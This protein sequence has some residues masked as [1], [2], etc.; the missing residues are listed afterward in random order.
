M[1]Q[2]EHDGPMSQIPAA[3]FGESWHLHVDV[4]I[5]TVARAELHEHIL[6]PP[7]QPWCDLCPGTRTEELDEPA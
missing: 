4:Q 5:H 6:F 1:R 2:T 3:R 7:F